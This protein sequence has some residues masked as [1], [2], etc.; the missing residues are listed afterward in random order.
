MINLYINNASTLN[1]LDIN[2]LEK[3]EIL[4]KRNISSFCDVVI[5]IANNTTQD[6][7]QMDRRRKQSDF[8]LNNK[9][10]L[11]KDCHRINIIYF[12]S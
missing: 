2:I 12:F 8:I 3:L 5:Y 10:N 4:Q 7:K 9:F 6:S 11:V 1:N